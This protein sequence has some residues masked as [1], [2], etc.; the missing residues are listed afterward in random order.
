MGASQITQW[1]KVPATKFDQ[2]LSTTP[3]MVEGEN[4]LLEAVH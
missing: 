2:V 3:Y 4:Q 1:V